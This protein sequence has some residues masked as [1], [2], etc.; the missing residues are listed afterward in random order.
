MDT[1]NPKGD[2]DLSVLVHC[3]CV[4]TKKA[5]SATHVRSRLAQSARA[6]CSHCASSGGTAASSAALDAAKRARALASGSSA[7]RRDAHSAKSA[8]KAYLRRNDTKR[9][10]F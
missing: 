4:W 7:A 2:I 6:H 5:I 1:R 8:A 10:V 9:C 3:D